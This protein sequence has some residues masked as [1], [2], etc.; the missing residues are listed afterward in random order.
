MDTLF[1]DARAAR[2]AAV[3][4]VDAHAE[5][6][7]KELALEAVRRTCEALPEFI[8]DDIW[9]VG[10]LPSAREDRALGAV[11]RRAA[12]EGLCVRTDR[13]RPSVRSHLSPKPVWRSLLYAGVRAA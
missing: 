7:W 12:R 2:D 8:C 6:E 11:M 4:A 3:T 9:E 5:P 1:D 13:T 10:Q